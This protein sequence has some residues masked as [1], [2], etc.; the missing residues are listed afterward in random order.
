MA[1]RYTHQSL[2]TYDMRTHALDQRAQLL[3]LVANHAHAAIAKDDVC[4]VIIREQD[5]RGALR[6]ALSEGYLQRSDTTRGNYVQGSLPKELSFR[7]DLWIVAYDAPWDL[8]RKATLLYAC[9]AV[10]MLNRKGMWPGQALRQVIGC[11]R[12]LWGGV[13]DLLEH[14]DTPFVDGPYSPEGVFCHVEGG[15]ELY[16]DMLAEIAPD[17]EDFIPN[18]YEYVFSGGDMS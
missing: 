10:H 2:T 14:D 5:W 15:Y 7:H 17:R 11:P 8:E 13:S 16:E 12:E 4:P 18:R 3:G 6:K 1:D 9:T